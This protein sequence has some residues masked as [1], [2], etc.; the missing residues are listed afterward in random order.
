MRSFSEYM[1]LN[2]AVKIGKYLTAKD[3]KVFEQLL[4]DK[5][6]K[7]FCI[8][9]Y[10]NITLFQVYYKKEAIGF[11]GIKIHGKNNDMLNFYLEATGWCTKSGAERFTKLAVQLR[12]IAEKNAPWMYFS[13]KLDRSRFTNF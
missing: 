2:E 11:G 5:D 6:L 13:S 12:S 3:S 4:E 9:A 8:A 7:F 1:E 10:D